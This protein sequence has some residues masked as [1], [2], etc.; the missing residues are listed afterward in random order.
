MDR[1]KVLRQ[2]KADLLTEAT[3]LT[4]KAD[5]GTITDEEKARLD[6][7]I[8]E[9]GDLDKVNASIKQEERLMDE[10]RTMTPASNVSGDTPA[11]ASARL[12]AQPKAGDEDK[13]KFASFGEQL[14][15]VARAGMNKGVAHQIIDPRLV[16]FAGGAGANESTP[17][18]GGFL[19]QQ[20]FSL[21]FLQLMHEMGELLSRVR[22]IPISANSNGI[23]LPAIDETSRANGSRMG[24]VQAYW[25]DEGDAVTASKPKF[26]N[27]DMRL[28]KLLAVGYATDELLADAPALEAVMQTAFV[29]EL[30]FKSE[31]AI[32]SGTGAGQPLGILNSGAVV[33]VTPASGQAASSLTTQNILDMWSRLPLRSRK[34]AVWVINQEVEQQLYQLVLGSGTAVLLLYRPPGATAGQQYGELLGRPVIPIEYASALGTA[35]DIILFD[36]QQYVM[37][38]KNGLQQASSMHVRF[39]TDEMTFR[40]TFRVDGQPVWRTTL[41][42]FKGN[43]TLSPYV[44]LGLRNS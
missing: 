34:N 8:A 33:T 30:T 18:E 9:G 12:P 24:G 27:M 32:I 17:S 29:E 26:R 6:A 44:V 37:I 7:L 16:Y 4:A 5:A 31:D 42:P 35:G 15:S 36:P 38:D 13:T 21:A 41:T 3:A 11:E 10:R 39:L 22:R 20:D 40:F 1:I 2:R 23:I 43:N 25:A 19:V 14:V 28:K